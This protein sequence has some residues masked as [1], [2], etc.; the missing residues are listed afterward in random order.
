[1]SPRGPKE[2]IM[3]MAVVKG[4]EMSGSS[5]TASSAASHR[6][7]SPPR[8]AVWAKRS[9]SAVPQKP[10][11][12]ASSRLLT[13]A[14]RWLGSPSVASTL[15]RVKRP[16][17]TKARWSSRVSGKRTKRPS[18]TQSPS[19]VRSS[20]GSRRSR[21]AAVTPGS[22]RRVQDFGDPAVHNALAVGP[23]VGVVDGEDLGALQH[24]G[25]ARLGLHLGMRRHEV[26]LVLG[27][28]R[29]HGGARCPVDQLLAELRVLGAL[30]E[31]DGLC[32]G[33]DALAGKADRDV[34]ALGLGVQRV[35]DEEDPP[36]RLAESH[37][38]R[39]AA[40]ALGIDLHVL[41][42]LLHVVEGLVLL[43]A[44]DLED[45]EEPRHRGA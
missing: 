25:Q 12:A 40:T 19:A 42:Q 29:L 36:P 14:R 39:A 15:P 33:A 4:G 10:T 32:R 22:L 11:S 7:P 2:K 20:A 31:R 1:M 8:A 6:R 18:S 44:I 17:S 37:R 24:L 34:V 9:P 38:Q 5:A 35:H 23:G 13:K 26:D 45:R 16:S 41:A 21:R 43:A 27:V 30:D 28:E 3:V